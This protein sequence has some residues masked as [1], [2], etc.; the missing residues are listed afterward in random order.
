MASCNTN[1]G[2]KTK[3]TLDEVKLSK[4]KVSF[5]L[6]DSNGEIMDKTTLTELKLKLQI[7]R[8][9]MRLKKQQEM[10]RRNNAKNLRNSSSGCESCKFHLTKLRNIWKLC[11]EYDSDSSS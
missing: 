4:L 9:Q 6:D 1:V 5:V 8:L 11:D 3:K 2:M 7:K 10:T